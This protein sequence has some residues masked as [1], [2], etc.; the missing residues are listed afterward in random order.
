MTE[1]KKAENLV[2]VS[3]RQGLQM[4]LVEADIVLGY[5]EG[6]GF[7]LMS[8]EKFQMALHDTEEIGRAHV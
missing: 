2:A 1:I 3:V 6:H 8:D 7:A 5:I 4:N